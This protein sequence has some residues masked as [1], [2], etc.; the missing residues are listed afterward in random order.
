MIPPGI[1]SRLAA[2]ARIVSRADSSQRMCR[3]L[4]APITRYSAAFANTVRGV[5]TNARIGRIHQR[6]WLL[7]SDRN[8]KYE[9]T[10]NRRRATTSSQRLAFGEADRWLKAFSNRPTRAFQ[11]SA[12]LVPDVASVP[13]IS[14]S[15][16]CSTGWSIGSS[17]GPG[18]APWGVGDDWTTA[19]IL[20]GHA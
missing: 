4:I 10:P 16:A 9:M 2:V 20:G 3:L 1:G 8:E 18:R 15:P 5:V 17:P 11:R 6:N 19:A 7:S 12:R 13:G 14:P